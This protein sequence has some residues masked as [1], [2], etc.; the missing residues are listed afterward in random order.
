MTAAANVHGYYS[1]GQ[2]FQFQKTK[3][4][5]LYDSYFSE[6]HMVVTD[7]KVKHNKNETHI[8]GTFGILSKIYGRDFLQKKLT[9]FNR[10][11]LL[12]KTLLYHRYF[13]RL[14]MHLWVSDG[15]TYHNFLRV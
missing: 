13:T 4:E 2:S 1:T 3:C 8:T 5:K 12:Q 6:N 10:Y 9:A 11:I 7:D 14:L 15:N